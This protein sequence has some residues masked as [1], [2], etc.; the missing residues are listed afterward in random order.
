[1]E[2]F[3]NTK[4]RT[5]DGAP[6]PYH[7]YWWE[8]IDGTRVMGMHEAAY[9][10]WASA[11]KLRS[12]ERDVRAKGGVRASLVPF[13]FGDGGGGA[14]V[15]DL[16]LVSRWQELPFM[17]GLRYAHVGSFVDELARSFQQAD[18]VPVQSKQLYLEAHRG[19]YTSVA[20]IKYL[21]RHSENRLMETELWSALA[22]LRTGCAYP[23]DALGRAWRKTLLNQFHDILPGS[24]IRQVYVDAEEDAAI[25]LGIC[26]EAEAAALATLAGLSGEW[27]VANSHSQP[28][29]GYVRL[30][31]G[32]ALPGSQR[33]TGPDGRASRLAWVRDVPAWSVA[34]LVPAVPDHAAFHWDGVELE[35]PFWRVQLSRPTGN[36]F[37]NAGVVTSLF[38]KTHG[39]QLAKGHLND[40]QFFAD[41]PDSC[42]IWEQNPVGPSLARD[43]V[44]NATCEVVATGPLAFIFRRTLETE[45]S[46][47][48]QD[49][50]FHAFTARIDFHAYVDWHERRTM[51]KAVFPFGIDAPCS[52]AETAFGFHVWENDPESAAGKSRFETPMH[53]WVSVA[54]GRSGAA[55]LND[56]KY[57]YGAVGG[58]VS[59]TLLKSAPYAQYHPDPG[60]VNPLKQVAQPDDWAD[61]GIHAFT[62]SLHPHAG[63][64]PDGQ[65]LLESHLLNRPLKP[66]LGQP[67]AS[68]ICIGA[69]NVVADTLKAAEDGDGF[70][71]RLYEALG[72]TTDTSVFLSE[73]I[74]SLKPC[75]ILERPLGD[76]I[77]GHVTPL[78][79][80]PFEV[81]SLRLR[82][83]R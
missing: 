59:L 10:N 67:V 14:T 4:I 31:A 18:D 11:G 53:R 27:T 50:C 24:S 47:I 52:K 60:E 76:P 41:A 82:I 46:L 5:V 7:N 64:T 75:D 66:R 19:T 6:N 79:F 38:D 28:V 83:D 51:L 22:T 16:E 69:A 71:L 30:A 81:K 25:A 12:W 29:S 77:P 23:T 58:T 3:F 61:Q 49:V 80:R 57:G 39:R 21:N 17:P 34:P 72:Q 42:E 37:A 70:I 36:C 63:D 20:R 74:A 56:C 13:G 35:T 65:T 32:T 43:L 40:L 68:A 26:D 1:V 73:G 55:L 2:L 48:R 8:G 78:T 9:I 62:Y 33:V 54:D 45:R 44:V 15:E